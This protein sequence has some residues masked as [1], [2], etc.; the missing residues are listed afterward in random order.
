VIYLCAMIAGA[1]L[2]DL[3]HSQPYLAVGASGAIS[4]ILGALLCLW[5]L[6]K[7]DLST[8]FFLINIGLN[9]A[10]TLSSQRIDWVA[11]VGGFAAGL[12]VCALI[13]LLERAN[14]LAFR[15]K[16]PE[17]VKINGA[18]LGAMLGVLMWRNKPGTPA[19]GSSEDWFLLL[20][21]LASC[22]AA[23]KLVDLVLSLK[24]GLAIIVV[25]FSVANAGLALLAAKM[26]AL[27]PGLSCASPP[28][29]AQGLVETLV[30]LACSN[31]QVTIAI[32]A[33][34]VFAATL[35]LY[36]QELARGIRDVGF[37]GGSMR[38]ERKRRQ[39]I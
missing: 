38:A 21:Y 1:I 7:I 27:L 37:V 4:G 13:D 19:P 24:R 8:Q 14:R 35:L 5:I 28:L 16:F 18:I 12:I 6:G 15:C 2:S 30:D 31:S 22:L 29:G 25:A 20:A 34:G 33:A 26:A 39:G 10:L 23:I 11:H 32:I 17:L 36:S 9:A 3:H